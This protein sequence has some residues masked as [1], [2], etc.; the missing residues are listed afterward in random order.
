MV[1]LILNGGLF[2]LRSLHL[3]WS[4]KYQNLMKRAQMVYLDWSGGLALI[5]SD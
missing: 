5:A 1:T 3:I 2:F 4:E